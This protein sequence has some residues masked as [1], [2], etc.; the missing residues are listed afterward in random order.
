MKVFNATANG[1]SQ[2]E[3]NDYSVVIEGQV[4]AWLWSVVEFYLHEVHNMNA[5][6]KDTIQLSVYFI[7]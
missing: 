2:K 1:F 6:W 7:S 3:K 5:Q 4:T